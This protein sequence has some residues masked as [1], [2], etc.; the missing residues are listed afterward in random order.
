MNLGDDT[1]HVN[2]GVFDG[3]NEIK[4]LV[5]SIPMEKWEEFT[6]RQDSFHVHKKTKTI[7][8]C[9]SDMNNMNQQELPQYAEFKYIFDTLIDAVKESVDA[10]YG[11][12]HNH[13]RAMLAK[14]PAH[15]EIPTHI[16]G[17]PIFEVCRRVHIPIITNPDANIIMGE[18]SRVIEMSEGDIVEINN[19]LLHGAVN[20]G[21]EDRI[22]FICDVEPK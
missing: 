11:V 17:A 4:T 14:L 18:D 15:E 2:F 1:T 9:W 19:R 7:G 6:F 21:Y 3:I 12:P 5:K 10:Y 8:A 13:T 20:N 16:D 22:H